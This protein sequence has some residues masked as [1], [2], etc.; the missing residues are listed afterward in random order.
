MWLASFRSNQ[1]K[2]LV[3]PITAANPIKYSKLNKKV[4]LGGAGSLVIAFIIS[5]IKVI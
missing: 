5:I 2:Y 4:R 1:I 3:G